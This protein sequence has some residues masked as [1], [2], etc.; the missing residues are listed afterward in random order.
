MVLFVSFKNLYWK[1]NYLHTWATWTILIMNVHTCTDT[2]VHTTFSQYIFS[3]RR[4]KGA[5]T[6]LLAALALLQCMYFYY[7]SM[8][9]IFNCKKGASET[10]TLFRTFLFSSLWKKLSTEEYTRFCMPYIFDVFSSGC[11][12]LILSSLLYMYVWRQPDL[13]LFL[14]E[15][16]LLLFIFSC[17]SYA[18]LFLI[19]LFSLFTHLAKFSHPLSEYV[20]FYNLKN[21]NKRT[22]SG[23]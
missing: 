8:Y 22:R 3:G 14:G 21:V 6:W 7:F 19:L 18:I 23:K 11:V 15:E 9:T 2:K 4:V 20:R 16:V 5:L 17:F 10:T 13:K 1:Y 12:P